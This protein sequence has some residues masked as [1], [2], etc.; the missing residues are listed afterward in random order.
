MKVILFFRN[1]LVLL[2]VFSVCIPAIGQQSTTNVSGTVISSED[3]KPIIGVSVIIKGTTTGMITDLNGKYSIDGVPSNA[4][5]VFSYVGMKKLEIEVSGKSVIDAILSPAIEALDDVVVI[6]YGTSK[7]RDLTGS[8]TSV[9][10]DDISDKPFTSPL[11]A[12]QGNVAGIVVT[13]TGQAG[14]SPSIRIRGVGSISNT[15]PLYVV[16]GIFLDN[17]DFLNNNDIEKMEILKDPSSLAMFGV[18]GANG[19]IIITTKQALVGQTNVEISSYVGIQ[20]VNKLISL[21]NASQ[22]Q[23]LY[24]QQLANVGDPAYDFSQLTANTNW[25]DLILR[26]AIITNNDFRVTSGT[27]KNQTAFS[28]NYFKQD[29]VL[30]YEDYSRVTAHLKDD[31]KVSKFFRI[32]GDMNMSR[33]DK[34]AATASINSALWASPVFEPMG[35]NGIYNSPPSFQK[36]Q[37][38]NPVSKMNILK[39]KSPQYGYRFVG[40]AYAELTILKDFVF[41]SVAYTDLGFTSGKTYTPRYVIGADSAY[42]NFTTG[43]NQTQDNYTTWQTDNTLTFSKTFASV[44]SLT[45][46]AGY[47]VQFKRSDGISGS[48]VGLDTDIPN[49]PIFWYLNMGTPNTN[50][51]NSGTA[52]EQAFTSY[53]FRVNYSYASKYLLNAS[54]RMDGTSKFSPYNQWGYFP[55]IGLGWVLSEEDFMKS[56][57]VISFL[58]LKASWGRLG[59]DKV[60]NYLYYPVLNSGTSAVFGESVYAAVVPAYLPNPNIHWEVMQGSDLGFELFALKNKL[61]FEGDYYNR[62]TKDILVT[63]E[64]PGAVGSNQSLT[65]AGT[66]LNRGIEISVNWNEKLSPD[67]SY[68]IGANF[69]TIHNEVLSI[70]DNIGYNISNP[71]SITTIGHPVG[72]FYGY[73]QDGIFQDSAE[74]ANYPHLP[75]TKPGDI[76]YRDVNKDTLLTVKDRTYIGSP[77]PTY[78]YGGSFGLTFKNFDLNI[79]VQGVGG[80]YIYRQRSMATFAILNY[81]SNRL[82]AWTGPGTSNVEPILDNTRSNNYSLYSSY[83]LDK[84]DYFR[85]RNISLSYRLQGPAL[86]KMGIKGGK[87]YVNV[88]NLVT[89]T[90]ATGY[91]PEV[92]GD[93][94]VSFG[95]DNGSYPVPT[96][97]TVGINL[98]F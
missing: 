71:P 32:G 42:T 46:L 36:P 12:L 48:R 23:T 76:K 2:A 27:E 33:W 69:T 14:A 64:I 4:T 81:T 8:I 63:L 55:S 92:G 74:I 21:A 10:G 35:A 65:N 25:Q 79:D 93:S 52:E 30:K 67:W 70:G 26:S 53:L 19:V 47:T 22:F 49:D 56:Q 72:A 62:Q 5:L 82:N 78:T 41:R 75:F 13:N 34:D 94:P 95:V 7:K 54:Y 85:I 20:K 68:S 73:V 60:G 89:F 98:N 50:E 66:I 88:Q 9:K 29:G 18:Q 90:K 84:G 40:S 97:Y 91:S 17:I 83:F 45:L 6:G 37:V 16:D 77:T 58:K 96:V 59:N 3:N 28:M 24:N 11:S 80:N 31:L 38:D 15:N 57:N 44:H 61:R 43:I 51:H 87:I 86:Q 39:G 1:L